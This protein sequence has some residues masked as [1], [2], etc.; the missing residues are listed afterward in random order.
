MDLFGAKL[1]TQDLNGTV[2]DHLI[3]VHVRLGARACLPDD[4]REVIIELPSDDL[5]SSLDD[6]ICDLGFKTKVQVRLRSTLLQQTEGFDYGKRH[7]LAFTSNLEVH[8][9]ALS[10]C[11]PVAI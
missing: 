8:E 6:G 9:R 7:A 10:L 4:E 1:A 2:G 5:I 11:T 3:R